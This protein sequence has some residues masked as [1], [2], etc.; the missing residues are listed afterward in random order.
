MSESPIGTSTVLSLA[1]ELM[2]Q[3]ALERADAAV[4]EALVRAPGDPDALYLRGI[5]AA[6]R[7]DHTTAI[8]ALR[9]AVAARPASAP[10]WL[11][12][13]NAYARSE[14]HAAAAQA[15]REV[16][17]REAGW[18]DAHYN[19]GI[20]LKRVGET[21]AA[22]RSLHAAW[23]IDPMMFD[24]AK[25]CVATIAECVRN[26]ERRPRF[27]PVALDRA[28]TPVCIVICSID[29]AKHDHVV[30]L[31]RRLFAD[32]PHEI[33]SIRDARSL[34]EAYNWAAQRTKAGI[35]LLSHDDVD[36]LA[37]D[38]AA[39]L[40]KHLSVFDVVGVI[41]ST[42]M[43]GPA[44][45]WSGHPHLRGWIT[46]RTPHEP[47]WRVDVLD[48]RPVAGDVS[49]L[50]GVLL[51]ARRAVLAAVP[52]DAVNFDGFHLYDVDW[53]YRAARGGFRLGAA[54]DLLLVHA[55]RGRYA[56][57][58]E[59]YAE[60]FCTK[61]ATGTSPPAPSSFFGATLDGPEQVRAFYA[62]LTELENAAPD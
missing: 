35:V 9:Q 50:D 33:V 10:A 57:K 27:T 52:F 24:A 25:L 61:H 15:Y 26:A 21:P 41:G 60:R 31:Y 62:W 6:R 11:A 30:A 38:F 4:T 7:S 51:A 59:R 43:G 48:P 53:S 56:A 32:V 16:I 17:A 44:I 23:T 49:I 47:G 5:I 14:Q 22:A 46:H 1:Q 12:L 54:G 42:R 20:M 13:G 39:R 8:A 3:G 19:L 37:P 36:V 58:W 2:R 28:P 45:G 29:D 34:A 55:S 40:L 18:A